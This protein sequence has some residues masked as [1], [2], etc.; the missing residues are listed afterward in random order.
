MTPKFSIYLAGDN[1]DLENLQNL[2][3]QYTI[4]DY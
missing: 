4:Q 1:Y 3:R 2:G